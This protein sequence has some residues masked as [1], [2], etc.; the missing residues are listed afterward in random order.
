MFA[1]KLEDILEYFSLKKVI[2]KLNFRAKRIAFKT[3][4]WTYN[5]GKIN[6]ANFCAKNSKFSK[7][8]FLTFIA[9]KSVLAK[10]F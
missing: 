1:P 10:H 6:L 9:F 8:N 5:G 3:Q 2:K 7:P 4:S